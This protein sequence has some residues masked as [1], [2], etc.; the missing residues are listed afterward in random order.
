MSR[1]KNPIVAILPRSD[2][3]LLIAIIS[4]ASW[5]AHR[6]LLPD[7]PHAALVNSLRIRARKK[8]NAGATAQLGGEGRDSGGP[9][10]RN[11]R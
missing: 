8:R 1:V 10:V 11:P 4:R 7:S 6:R 2:L 9:D 5:E 3:A